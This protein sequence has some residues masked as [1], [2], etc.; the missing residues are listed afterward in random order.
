MLS[1]KWENGVLGDTFAGIAYNQSLNGM[2]WNQRLKFV[3]ILSNGYA[4][5]CFR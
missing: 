5:G 4:I 2:E 3:H 1:K